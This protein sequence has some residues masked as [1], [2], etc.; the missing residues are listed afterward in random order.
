MADLSRYFSGYLTRFNEL[1][2]KVKEDSVLAIKPIC[3][4]YAARHFQNAFDDA[5]SYYP[6]GPFITEGG[7]SEKKFEISYIGTSSYKKI[8]SLETGKKLAPQQFNM[9]TPFSGRDT[10]KFYSRLKFINDYTTFN[11]EFEDILKILPDDEREYVTGALLL[12]DKFSFLGKV[13]SAIIRTG[14]SKQV[15]PHPAQAE[16]LAAI[17]PNLLKSGNKTIMTQY[18]YSLQSTY[19][20][21]EGFALTYCEG[22]PTIMNPEHLDLLMTDMKFRYPGVL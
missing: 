16:R 2:N 6:F 14:F 15:R 22:P 5:R 3:L 10:R 7:S 9:L 18:Q 19:F 20:Y 11:L 21:R 13:I 1:A 17:F 12:F 8:S 4:D